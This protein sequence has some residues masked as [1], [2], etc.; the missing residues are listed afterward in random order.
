MLLEEYRDIPLNTEHI[1][2]RI[3]LIRWKLVFKT[4]VVCFFSTWG[5]YW[6]LKSSSDMNTPIFFWVFFCTC[7]SLSK[8]YSSLSS[9]YLSTACGSIMFLPIYWNSVNQSGY[10]TDTSVAV[11]HPYSIDWQRCHKDEHV[12][13]PVLQKYNCLR[14]GL[15]P[16]ISE[17]IKWLSVC[18]LIKRFVYLHEVD[19]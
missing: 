14:K 3:T 12:C 11:P 15:I 1:P 8:C 10:L 2:I 4:K 16:Y 5:L 17:A 9:L 7:S 13:L 18:K 6:A 19:H